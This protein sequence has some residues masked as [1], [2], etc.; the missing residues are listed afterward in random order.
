MEQVLNVNLASLTWLL[1]DLVRLVWLDDFL[2]Q[3]REVVLRLP[4]LQE[5]D[6]EPL[7]KG[8]KWIEVRGKGIKEAI[9]G[10]DSDFTIDYSGADKGSLSIESRGPAKL[11]LTCAYS[12]INLDLY[13][14]YFLLCR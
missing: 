1:S 8:D 9:V 13:I 12:K 7:D 4:E 10:I 11:D 2:P 3:L 6:I 14:Q 5:P